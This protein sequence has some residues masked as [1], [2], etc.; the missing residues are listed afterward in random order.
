VYARREESS[1]HDSSRKR[2]MQSASPAKISSGAREIEKNLEKEEFS[3]TYI[4]PYAVAGSQRTRKICTHIHPC[5]CVYT[6]LSLCRRGRC[7]QSRF[8]LVELESASSVLA[9]KKTHRNP[10]SSLDFAAGFP[11]HFFP[12]HFS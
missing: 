9:S 3:A 1:S 12:Y 7:F 5:V 4:I 6:Y 11:S 8:Y 2:R 10:S